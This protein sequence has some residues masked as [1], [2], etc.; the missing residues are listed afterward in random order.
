MRLEGPL[1]SV[2]SPPREK[3]RGEAAGELVLGQGRNSPRTQAWTSCA[4]CPHLLRSQT[5]PSESYRGRSS[6]Q[7]SGCEGP[8][9]EGGSSL[10]FVP[11]PD[12]PVWVGL[13]CGP[14]TRGTGLPGGGA[15]V[16]AEP[17][18][19]PPSPKPDYRACWSALL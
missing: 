6:A 5:H 18:G 16:A 15:E 14:R 3:K 7:I 4:L 9:L 2:S 19:T 8:G 1:R 11:F 10:D 17:Q 12:V 13:V